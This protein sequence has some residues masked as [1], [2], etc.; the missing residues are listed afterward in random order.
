[1]E[2]NLEPDPRVERTRA[3]V[4]EAALN[5]LR[6]EGPGA[7]THQRVS[8]E[9]GIGRATVYRHWPDR[10]RLVLD[11]L[12]SLSLSLSLEP[13]AGV[14]FRDGIV[15]QLQELCDRL[16]SPAFPAFGSLIAQAEWDPE[17]RQLLDRLEQN[18]SSGLNRLLELEIRAGRIEPGL[19]PETCV[20]LIAG[21]YFFERLV[22]G[23][24]R[25]RDSVETHVDSLLRTWKP[26]RVAGPPSPGEG[27]QSR[28]GP[29]GTV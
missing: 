24:I 22:L 27:M 15:R 17:C 2:G 5:L 26:R 21:P 23:R 12:E 14:G 16:D 1:M 8:R 4:L 20:S 19:S 29:G 18:A 25:S 28:C 7:V 6:T 3:R 10:G 9:A 13:P 11:A